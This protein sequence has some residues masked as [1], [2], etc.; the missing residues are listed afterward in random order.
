M[1]GPVLFACDLDHTLLY[2]RAAAASAGPLEV[3]EHVEARPLS[4]VTPRALRL[5]ARVRAC[6]LLV[7]ATTRTLSQYRRVELFAGERTP[8]YAV[9]SNGGQLLERG[10]PDP[11]WH[12]AARRRLDGGPEPAE[13]AGWLAETGAGWA[14]RVRV[15]DELFAYALVERSRVPPAALA[16]LAARLGEWGWELS[17]QGRKL[18]ALPA[19]LDKWP[20]V[21][22]VARRSGARR[23]LAAG[24]SLLDRRL[25]DQADAAF[26]PA[27]GDLAAAGYT[28]ASTTLATGAL[29]GEELLELV[30]DVLD[31]PPTPPDGS[32]VHCAGRD[33][34]FLRVIQGVPERP[35]LAGPAHR[36]RR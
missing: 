3:V 18:Y 14:V 19:G 27:H 24:D 29:A 1:R 13:V 26:Q 9:T 12:R 10:R 15:A 35:Q 33:V 34:G 22:E 11:D 16:E 2:S 21:A 7:P 28:V 4:F 23:V 25:L 8:E 20:A 30:A 17:A 5:L 31:C 6:A 36:H 32:G